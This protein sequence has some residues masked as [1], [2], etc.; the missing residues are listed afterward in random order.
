MVFAHHFHQNRFNY[1]DQ[2][3]QLLSLK[4][5]VDIFTIF[6]SNT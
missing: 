2:L 3:G 6:I 5:A 4:K 1:F